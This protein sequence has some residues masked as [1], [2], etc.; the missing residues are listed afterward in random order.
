MMTQRQI[1]AGLVALLVG[2]TLT[3]TGCKKPASEKS[4][5]AG[6]SQAADRKENSGTFT[7]PEFDENQLSPGLQ[8]KIASARREVLRAPDDQMKLADLG[9]LCYAHGFTDVATT[10]FKQATVVA[11]EQWRWWYWLGLAYERAG[12][13]DKAIATYEEL[14]KLNEKH[15]ATCVRLG[16]LLMD[17]QPERAGE[18]FRNV[19][20]SEGNPNRLT[21]MIAL[22]RLS[23]KSGKPQEAVEH[24][25]RGL[26]LAP[27]FGPAHAGL[28]AAYEALG[29]QTKAG[30]H[31]AQATEQEEIRPLLDPLEVALLQQGLDLTTLLNMALAKAERQD[32]VGAERFLQDAMDVDDTDTGVRNVLG[33]VLGMQ[34][35]HE[36]AAREFAAILETEKGRDYMPAKVNLAIM[37]AAME[38]WPESEK[39]IDE[40]L[41][42][43]PA[44]ADALRLY[45]SVALSQGAPDKAV[46]AL[47]NAAA[48]KPDDAMV[49]YQNGVLF[50]EMQMVDR[51]EASLKRAIELNP[52]LTPALYGLG[53][54]ALNRGD[55]EGARQQ[56]LTA[57][58]SNPTVLVSR[59]ALLA[60]YVEDRNWEAANK[61]VRDGL[62]LTPNSPQLMNYLA[63]NLATCP[64]ENWRKPEEAIQ[65]AETACESTNYQNHEL[66][67]TLATAYAAAG[68]FEEAVKWSDRAIELA[69]RS[70]NARMLQEY[71]DRKTLF[72]QREPYIEP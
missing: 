25:E 40:V 27:N 42:K 61:L 47:D 9:A 58:E 34:G 70:D 49:H 17:K 19:L 55:R 5:A 18:L 64:D 37:L 4:E 54:I 50:Q 60:L 1:A 10:C 56:W 2:A 14:L 72:E 7:L 57:L 44:R 11:P 39:H 45:C 29:D 3:L 66:L 59:S 69:L 6:A 62:E 26:V 43:E 13:P 67:D 33:R 24:F 31:R 68:R 52:G 8:M 21:A 38:Q 63:W 41:A 15:P 71:R 46:Q 36:E 23:L 51:A 35:R 30:G 16:S 20:D 22:G 12:Q 48:A 28:V 53:M 32:F 65:I